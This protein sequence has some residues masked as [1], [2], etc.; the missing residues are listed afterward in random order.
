MELILG[1]DLGSSGDKA[2]I[3][4]KHGKVL[5]EAYCTYE[6]FFSADGGAVQKPEDWWKAV[7]IAT[8]TVIEK[9]QICP[10]DI[11]AISFGA[12]GNALL[13]VDKKGNALK[14]SAVIWMDS[15]SRNEAKFLMEHIP[16][17]RYYEITGNA[18]EMLGKKIKSAKGEEYQCLG[19]FD[20]ETEET[21]RRI[22]GDAV[23]EN[24]FSEK[25]TFCKELKDLLADNLTIGF[26]NKC[27]N[28][29][30]EEN[31]Q[32]TFKMLLGVGDDN[33]K[34][35]DGV[36]EG[37]IF[38]THLIGPLMIKNPH[39]LKFFAWKILKNREE[40]SKAQKVLT[41][42]TPLESK[43]YLISVNELKNRISQEN[44]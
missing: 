32:Q 41:A 36:F 2:C 35:F 10:K 40:E 43:A 19:F 4:D 3:F 1:H 44:N 23:C 16:E 31:H 42:D 37:N 34:S 13:P 18:F 24:V 30:W 12:Q 39:M 8:K 22:T 21:A 15:R 20:F 5:A 33:T 25:L 27:T 38:G 6:T 29:K 7:C 26:V 9:A 14:D 28:T 11:V 17:E